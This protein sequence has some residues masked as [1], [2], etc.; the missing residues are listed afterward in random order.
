MRGG[1]KVAYLTL[2]HRHASTTQQKQAKSQRVSS[3]LL[4][5]YEAREGE[6]ET[7][8]LR[9]NVSQDSCKGTAKCPLPATRM[10]T[11]TSRK[12][13]VLETAQLISS[14]RYVDASTGSL[15]PLC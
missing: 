11:N 4:S 6:R 8:T 9:R 1:R 2:L 3:Q 10:V 15:Y 13:F 7:V 5:G 12:A 14:I